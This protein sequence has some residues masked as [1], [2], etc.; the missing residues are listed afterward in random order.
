MN[1]EMEDSVRE[2][3]E[4]LFDKLNE[5]V[6]EDISYSDY[7]QM[8]DWLGEIENH[9]RRIGKKQDPMKP[10]KCQFE[11]LIKHGWDYQCPVCAKAVGMNEFSLDCTDEWPFCPSCGQK[12]DWED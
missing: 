4:F 1:D 3:F 8:N 10:E 5:L 12:L 7:V 9:V 6:I 2:Y 11:P